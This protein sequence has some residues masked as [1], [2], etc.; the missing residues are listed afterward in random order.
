[1]TSAATIALLLAL[2]AVGEGIPHEVSVRVLGRLHPN[3]VQI[4]R[5]GEVHVAVAS[6]G[7]LWVDARPVDGVHAFPPGRWRLAAPGAPSR[8]VAGT[9]SVSAQDDEVAVVLR[10]ALEDYV[11]SV[12]AAETER[13]TPIEALKALAVVVRSYAAARPGRHAGT[14]F[15]DLAHCQVMGTPVPGVHLASARVAARS[16]SG[17]VLRVEGGAVA[18]AGF[19]AACG[20][21][22]ADPLEAFGGEGTGAA[23]VPDPGCPLAPWQV[24]IPEHLLARV[25]SRELARGDA[26]PEPVRTEDLR[27]LRGKGGHVVRVSSGDSAIGGE[28]FA[29]ALDRSLGH[30]LVRSSRFEVQR[31]GGS[32]RLVGSGNGHGV[33]LCQAGSTRRA[34]EGQGYE[35]I[36][37]HYFPHARIDLDGS[38]LTPGSAGRPAPR[39]APLSRTSSR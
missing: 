28:A 13:G 17:Q 18:S 19:H 29:R 22:T 24:S 38:G 35:Q 2:G 12:V 1:V 21:H 25:A 26:A 27:F 36:L 39:W 20:G 7:R 4:S 5:S 34:A 31:S 9:V 15:C 3:S 23:A 10:S 32:L 11:E 37:R 8:E 30:G 33:G 6:G 16:T 14:D